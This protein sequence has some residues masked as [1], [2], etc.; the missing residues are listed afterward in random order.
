MMRLTQR[1]HVP[2]LLVRGALLHVIT[3]TSSR[4][5]ASRMT[6]RDSIEIRSTHT[7][8]ITFGQSFGVSP[9]ESMKGLGVLSPVFHFGV[10]EL[11]WRQMGWSKS[12]PL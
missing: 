7:M 2:V 6:M 12:W 9:H 8:N 3:P 10:S 5:S 4:S 11:G 1:L